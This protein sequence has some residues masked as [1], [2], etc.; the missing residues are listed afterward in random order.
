MICP[1]CAA[2]NAESMRYCGRCGSPLQTHS[3]VRERRNVSIVFIDLSGFSSMTREFEPERL[4][5]LADEVLTVV[6]GVIEDYD[7]YVDAFQGDGLIALFGA[8]HSHPD[9]PERAVRAAVAGLK[10]IENI[11]KAKGLNLK[12]RGGVN[13][14]VVIA[15]AV[16][17]GRVREYTVMGSAVN[18]AA[19]LETAASPGEVFVGPETLR[20][21]RHSISYEPVSPVSLQGFPNITEVYR[22]LS[23]NEDSSDDP[24]TQLEFIGRKEELAH[25]AQVFDTVIAT[26]LSSTLWLTGDAGIGKTRL[27]REFLT[28]IQARDPIKILWLEEQSLDTGAMWFQLAKQVFN[29]DDDDKVWGQLMKQGLDQY[30]PNEPRWQNYILGS[31]NLAEA[32]PWRRL[33]R[34]SVDRAFL[35]W[36]DLLRALVKK[37]ANLKGLLLV[38][39]HSSQGSSFGQFLDLLEQIDIPL[40]VLRTSRGKE[41]PAEVQ[42]LQLPPLNLEESMELVDQVANPIL[43]VA[44][45]SLVLQVGGVPANILELGRAL[46]ITPQGS[47]SGSLASLL[48]ARLDMLSSTARQ[49][50]AYAALTGE[51]AWE[52]LILELAGPEGDEALEELN[53][54]K[55]LIKE[56]ISSIAN[57]SEYRFQSELL[58]RAVLR[59]IPFTERPLLH[60][61]IA[62]WLENHAPLALSA[63][64]GRHFK[65]GKLHEAAYPHYLS[66]ADLAVSE[67]DKSQSYHYFEELLKLELSAHLL[68]QGA[69]AYAQ[70]ALSF[71]DSS[72][73]LTQLN[74]ADEWIELSSEM[75]RL[76]LRSVHKRLY[77]ELSAKLSSQS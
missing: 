74:A 58:R 23:F 7:G 51:H 77:D 28:Q 62:T 65:E 31:V 72:T 1:N 19:R 3:L 12:G 2:H 36:R 27:A 44:T 66:A 40:L 4:R 15:G 13:T 22:F 46:N 5:D 9:D 68:A 76:E 37:S 47:F 20:L 64:I 21:T 39:E 61:K 45:N 10:A 53:S 32:R 59:M 42:Q 30:L 6:A 57:E 8:P 70:A 41:V 18:L 17:S 11:G 75:E 34:R 26:Q 14:G 73:G 50:M 25:L 67:Q 48:Q 69:L 71:G 38:V 33:E 63:L 56:P 43:K 35:A 24:Y 49:L 55:L 52:S 60:L 16:G 29:L 54:E